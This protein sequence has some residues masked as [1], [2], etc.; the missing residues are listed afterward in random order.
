MSNSVSEQF[1]EPILQNVKH[2][3]G[4]DITWYIE[5]EGW[6]YPSWDYLTA[7]ITGCT[8]TM[9]FYTDELGGVTASFS[10]VTGDVVGVGSNG[11]G[12]FVFADDFFTA[13][14][15]GSYFYEVVYVN[16]TITKKPVRGLFILV[17]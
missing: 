16:G 13:G 8:L 15:A 2:T 11:L 9:N 5:L 7:D 3:I 17:T 14:D 1:Q 10:P 6:D 4:E 12:E